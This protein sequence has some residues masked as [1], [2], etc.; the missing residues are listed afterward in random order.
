MIFLKLL[1]EF[2][3]LLLLCKSGTTG[4]YGLFLLI[5]SECS[6]ECHDRI[7]FVLI[8][9]SLIVHDDVRNLLEIDTQKMH[10]LFWLHILGYTSESGYV[11]EEARDV[12]PLSIEFHFLKFVEDIYYEFL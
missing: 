10:E 9:E 1:I 8:D 7:S 2:L 6:P 4:E 3:Y 5:S 12:H 11:R